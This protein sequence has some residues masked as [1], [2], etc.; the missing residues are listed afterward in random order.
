MESA[1]RRFTK[2]LRFLNNM[3]YSHRLVSLDLE[4]FE[5]RCSHQDLLLTYKIVIGLIN[6]DSS[7]FLHCDVIVGYYTW[8]VLNCF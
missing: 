2:R 6:I 7:N 3:S 4:S 5:V 8:A 1:Q